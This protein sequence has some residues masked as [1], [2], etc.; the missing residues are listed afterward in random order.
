M[1]KTCNK[2]LNMYTIGASR[3]LFSFTTLAK[4]EQPR[5]NKFGR[6]KNS[7]DKNKTT[8]SLPERVQ[9]QSKI[10]LRSLKEAKVS[11]WPKLSFRSFVSSLDGVKQRHVPD[12]AER[13]GAVVVIADD[14]REE[15]AV[16]ED[17][18]L[19]LLR[20]PLRPWDPETLLAVRVEVVGE[21]DDIVPEFPDAKGV[22]E[23]RRMG[24]ESNARGQPEIGVE[25]NSGP[26]P[27]R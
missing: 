3:Q 14:E 1:L 26:L 9:F 21:S 7:V 2:H 5:D 17:D 4:P 16:L 27:F 25:S 19:G 6:Y 13:I 11:Q 18:C 10:L 23:V 20:V 24:L 12:I 22:D 8:S 15:R